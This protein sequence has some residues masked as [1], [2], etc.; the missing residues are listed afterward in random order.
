MA[1]EGVTDLKIVP[2]SLCREF[3]KEAELYDI[4]ATYNGTPNV[5][6]CRVLLDYQ[7]LIQYEFKFGI[8]EKLLDWI[9]HEAHI[10]KYEKE[11]NGH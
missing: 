10:R 1:L 3:K 6:I 8:E 7:G 9:R 2:V 4:T 11:E 5:L